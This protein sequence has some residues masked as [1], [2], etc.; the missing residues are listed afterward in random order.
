M[1][2]IS[3]ALVVAVLL[4]I[5]VGSTHVRSQAASA[6][7][8]KASFLLRFARFTTWPVAILPDDR[9]LS[10]CVSGDTGVAD[11]L[12]EMAHREKVDNRAVTVRRVGSGALDDC[13][14]MFLSGNQPADRQALLRA[15]AGKPVLTVGD[16]PDFAQS[17]GMINFFVKAERMSFAINPTAVER[18]GLKLSS[19]LLALALI[20]KE[21]THG[22]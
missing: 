6:P 13:H 12:D 14:V 1:S 18:A 5:L 20:V 10:I 3:S 11:W 19:R 9:K 22:P 16:A 15:A 17:G 4:G 8:L 2:P 21:V 7:E